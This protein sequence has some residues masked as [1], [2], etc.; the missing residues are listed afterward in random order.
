VH[1]VTGAKFPLNAVA[2]G[3]KFRFKG[4]EYTNP[5]SVEIALEYPE[6]FFV[7]YCST[8]GTNANSFL[9]FI[10]TKGV[11]D[12]SVWN[13]PW[14]LSGQGSTEP[15]RLQPG[16]EIPP[17][18]GP[19][20]MKNFLEC[21]RSRQTATNAPIE[22]GYSHAIATLMADEAFITGRRM[23]YDPAKKTIHAG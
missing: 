9:K 13:K 15:D 3:G 2:A 8:F 1:Y 12:A 6:G 7:R 11:M 21:A 17:A 10:G 18:E 23:V 5:D 19:H 22:A 16:A 20:H 14:V 4:D